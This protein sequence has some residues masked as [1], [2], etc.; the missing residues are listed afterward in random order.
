MSREKLGLAGE[1]FEYRDP[2][3]RVK[4]KQKVSLQIGTLWPLLKLAQNGIP[5]LVCTMDVSI[6]FPL[7][8]LN[9]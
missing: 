2:V 7:N 1:G 6:S 8:M 4:R 5:F 3:Q 9:I